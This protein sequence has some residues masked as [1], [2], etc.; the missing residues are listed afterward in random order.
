M[1]NVPKSIQKVNALTYGNTEAL[2]I[3]HRLLIYFAAAQKPYFC[4][5]NV[6]QIILD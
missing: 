5:Q 1:K 3:S 4:L 2:I 6:M